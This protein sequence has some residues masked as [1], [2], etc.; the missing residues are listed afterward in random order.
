MKS[1]FAAK[2]FL[3]CGI[4]FLFFSCKKE[5]NKDEPLAPYKSGV[6][7]IFDDS[8]VKNW[9]EADEVLRKYSWKGTFCVSNLNTLP[10]AEINKLL[11][12]LN[13]GHEIAGHSL[14]H[15]NAMQFV[16]QYGI[17]Q[18]LSQ[19]VNPMLAL[20]N[21]YGLK[22]TSFAYPY[23]ARSPEI[24]AYLLRQFQIIRGRDFGG[25]IPSKQDCYYN[26][27]RIVFGF[28]I[29]NNHTYF[30]AS[31]LL[32]LLEYAH[33]NNKILILC[34]HKT[35]NE[36]TANYQTEIKLLEFICDYMKKHHMKFYTLSELYDLK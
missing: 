9:F 22:V 25:Q 32:K 5:E 1:N 7:L 20:M 26:H 34:S 31:Y 21:F 10:L 23:G 30:S 24:D 36:A 4:L 28:D 33:K 12:L 29:D 8:Y 27:S 2:A 11:V 15:G 17:K 16:A 18:Y 19:E 13:E 3:F 14:H 6:V 35:V